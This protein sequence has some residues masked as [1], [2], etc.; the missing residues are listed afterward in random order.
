MGHHA[1][2]IDYLIYMNTIKAQP[3]I[4]LHCFSQMFMPEYI[5]H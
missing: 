4:H 1:I 3:S 2:E 5:I